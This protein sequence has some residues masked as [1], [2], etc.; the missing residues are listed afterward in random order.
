MYPTGVRRKNNARNK[1]W[2]LKSRS[3]KLSKQS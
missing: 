2:R 3:E 1:G